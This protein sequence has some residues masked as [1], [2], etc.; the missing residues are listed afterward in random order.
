MIFKNLYTYILLVCPFILSG[1]TINN[2]F[3]W[4]TGNLVGNFWGVS[5]ADL[6][7]DGLD[8]VIFTNNSGQSIFLM[9]TG[10]AF[11]QTVSPNGTANRSGAFIVDITNNCLSDIFL[12]GTGSVAFFETVNEPFDSPVNLTNFSVNNTRTVVFSDFNKD[13]NV[14]IFVA[15]RGSSNNNRFFVNNGDGTFTQSFQSVFN[16]FID[17]ISAVW[18]DIDNDGYDDLFITNYDSQ[19]NIIYKN[20][21]GTGFQKINNSALALPTFYGV[22]SSWGD[23]DGDGLPDVFI[24]NMGIGDVPQRN[25]F[26]KNLGNNNFQEIVIPGMSNV[27]TFTMGSNLIDIDNDGDL[28]IILV[29]G[30]PG[31]PAQSK[32]QVFINQGNNSFIQSTIGDFVLDMGI[33]TGLSV[34][35]FNN[36]GFLDAAVSNRS[37]GEP[38]KIYFNSAH[39]GHNWVKFNLKSNVGNYHAL[40]AKLKLYSNGGI[41]PQYRSVNPVNGFR[42]QSSFEVHFGLGPGSNVVIDSLV[43]QWPMDTTITYYDIAV[44]QSHALYLHN[45]NLILEDLDFDLSISCGDTISGLQLNLNDLD[46]GYELVF[47]SDA[48]FNNVIG[49]LNLLPLNNN[50]T[51]QYFF[52]NNEDN[53]FD[54]VG[55]I[56]VNLTIDSNVE[57]TTIEYPLSPAQDCITDLFLINE[58]NPNLGLLNWYAQPDLSALIT[59]GESFSFNTNPISRVYF[60]DPESLSLDDCEVTFSFID[61]ASLISNAIQLPQVIDLDNL[62][63]IFSNI[64]TP[65]N[66]KINDCFGVNAV[67]SEYTDCLELEYIN[68]FNRW[69][70]M[71]FTQKSPQLDCLW[72]GVTNS[73]EFVPEGT[74]F[75]E[76]KIKPIEKPLVGSVLISI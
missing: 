68:V 51:Q 3:D 63:E 56:T 24:G 13:G 57:T 40:G 28:D 71:I 10:S 15:A 47:A 26:F 60:L 33:S 50:L 31:L 7:G 46:F 8:D 39:N 42:G 16:D 53:C 23:V 5:A 20:L 2:N 30:Q 36:D 62:S 49:A 32:N 11:S 59:T 29:N 43:V 58:F 22:T 69:G 74:Y 66:D 65:N 70:K 72:S 1:Q 12:A 21:N 37:P 14:D 25:F 6:N 73:G 67:F 76:I 18:V 52:K 27:N 38:S 34:G 48:Q 44:N 75:Y 35:D 45:G 9:N 17:T 55:T 61:A 54:F 64:F 41:T 4:F 19:P